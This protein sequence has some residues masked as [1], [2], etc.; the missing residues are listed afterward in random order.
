MWWSSLRVW[1]N[2]H[3]LQT[4]RIAANTLDCYSPIVL[5]L[6]LDIFS[7]SALYVFL[8]IPHL[9]ADWIL[10]MPRCRVGGGF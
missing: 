1:I 4:Y 10:A 8:L 6:L 7:M 3:L 9:F 5:Q 2:E